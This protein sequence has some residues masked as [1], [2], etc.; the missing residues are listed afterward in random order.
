MVYYPKI[1]RHKTALWKHV[2]IP[3]YIQ[4]QVKVVTIISSLIHT[5]PNNFC[6]QEVVSAKLIRSM[7]W[8]RT[9]RSRFYLLVSQPLRIKLP[10]TMVTS[11]A[12]KSLIINITIPEDM[13]VGVC[14]SL[15]LMMGQAT[16][17]TIRQ[18]ITKVTALSIVATD[19]KI[20][21]DY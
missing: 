5:K 19:E 10:K 15:K 2:P 17:T 1:L 18:P 7:K 13:A 3:P 9:S 14:E 12:T 8:R 16:A 20:S 11:F 6:G 21:Y 4:V